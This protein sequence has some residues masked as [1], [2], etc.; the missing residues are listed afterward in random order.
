MRGVESVSAD[1]DEIH[2]HGTRR[3]AVAFGRLFWPEFVEVEGCVLLVSQYRPE[4]FRHWFDPLGGD[5]TGIEA[6]INHLHLYDLCLNDPNSAETRLP[7]LEELA[8]TLLK[9][10]ECALKE[11][12]PNKRF[13]F[14]FATEPDEYGPAITFF[15]E[16]PGNA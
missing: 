3:L 9:C 6:M 12:F 10:W 8:R 16:I 13:T 11:A 5:C 15:Q 1:W 7:E 14:D 2:V 4:N